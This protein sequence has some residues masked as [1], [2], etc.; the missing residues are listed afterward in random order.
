MARI[1]KGAL[2]KIEIVS[3]STKQF[4]EK[5]YSNTTVAA[6]AKELEMSQGNLTFHFSTKEHLLAKLVD[7]LCAYQ[8]SMMKDEANDG[9]SWIMALCLELSAMACACEDDE[10]IRD[11]LL[12]AYTCPMCLDIIRRNDTGRA[13]EVFGKY[14]SDWTEEQFA[15]A[16]VVVSG[17]EYATLN[18]AGEPVPLETRITCALQ[19]IL[20]IYN[21]PEEIQKAKLQK[22]LTL[23]YRSIGKRVFTNFKEY[24][25]RTNDQ[26]FHDVIKR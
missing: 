9:V 18:V 8:W 24:V 26:A 5:G 15:A 12:S 23:D 3:E 7:I 16:E 25:A 17:I 13:K 2:T 6:I 21:V 14:C 20:T 11:F 19:S 1:D 22:V 4:L 10:V